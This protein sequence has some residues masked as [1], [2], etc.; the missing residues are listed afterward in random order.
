[1]AAKNKQPYHDFVFDIKQRKFVGKFEEMYQQEDLQAFD[2]WYQEDTTH[3]TKRLAFC[4]LEQYN[5]NNILDVGCGKGAFT[6][7]LKKSNNSAKGCDLLADT[8]L[9]TYQRIFAV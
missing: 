9:Q 3:I 5:F 6:H 1:M 8:F 2:S 7:L 4:L